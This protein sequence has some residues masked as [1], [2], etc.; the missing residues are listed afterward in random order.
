MS[1]GI[2]TVIAPCDMVGTIKGQQDKEARN[3]KFEIDTSVSTHPQALLDLMA[4]FE[5]ALAAIQQL[6]PEARETQF[7]PYFI[8]I[9]SAAQL[10]L[11]GSNASPE[12]AKQTLAITVA[13]LIDDVGPSIK[14]GNLQKLSV[15]AVTLSVFF[16]L[17]YAFFSWSPAHF[18][19]LTRCLGELV[20]DPERV[21]CFMILWIGAFLGVVLSY[22]VR[23]MDFKLADLV[24]P[25]D[26]LLLPKSRLLFVGCIAMVMGYLLVLQIVEFKIGNT[27]SSY[28]MKSDPNI[29]FLVGVACGFSEK[30]FSAKIAKKLTDM[31]SIK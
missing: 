13:R 1:I 18:K 8:Q 3:I 9:L 30:A 4:E 23:T 12:I 7:R 28:D 26:D 27:F 15:A 10:G 20:I 2:C 21:R 5:R 14:N 17:A 31:L 29:A 25:S 24:K 22:G 11:V 19:T 16:L 6:F